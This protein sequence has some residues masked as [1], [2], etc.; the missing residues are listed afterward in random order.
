LHHKHNHLLSRAKFKAML[1]KKLACA[2][3]I[4]KHTRARVG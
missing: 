2:L 4:H 1:Y 3:Q